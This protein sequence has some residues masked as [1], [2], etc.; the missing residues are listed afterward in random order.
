MLLLG[1]RDTTE[2]R[3]GAGGG[4]EWWTFVVRNK[5]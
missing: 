1:V 3:I 2:R 4:E 5:Q